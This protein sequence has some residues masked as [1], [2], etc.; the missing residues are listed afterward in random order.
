[1]TAPPI[2]LQHFQSAFSR[3]LRD[4]ESETLPDVPPRQGALYETLL[5]NNLCGFIDRCFPVSKQR[6][7]AESWRSL[8]R[9]F[10]RMHACKSPYFREIPCEFLTYIQ[11]NEVDL[12]AWLP[13]LLHYEWIEL[14]VTTDPAELPVELPANDR[15]KLEINP[16]LYNLQ[17]NWPVHRLTTDTGVD[18]LP[19]PGAINCLLVYRDRAHKVQFMQVNPL[20]ACLLQLLAESPSHP[21]Q[22]ADALFQLFPTMNRQQ[23]SAQTDLLLTGLLRDEA[24]FAGRHL[25]DE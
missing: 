23:L 16:T 18:E 2:T 22:L 5:F 9:R 7:N 24:I 17:Y 6:M 19:T 1:M 15:A 10:Y 12:P 11:E 25:A 14:A 3:G 4:P 13:E 21:G 8:C 20:T